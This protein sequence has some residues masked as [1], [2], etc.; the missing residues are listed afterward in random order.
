MKLLRVNG[1]RKQTGSSHISCHTTTRLQP[2]EH[3]TTP[4]AV[5]Y[6]QRLWRQVEEEEVEEVEAEVED[7]GRKLHV[8]Q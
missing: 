4:S 6:Q 1:G 2:N 7:M 8:K 5:N 3:S